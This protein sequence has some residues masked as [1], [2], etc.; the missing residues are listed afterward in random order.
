MI[1]E[2]Y[3][4][5]TF[6]F[7]EETVQQYGSAHKPRNADEELALSAAAFEYAVLVWQYLALPEEAKPWA[8]EKLREYRWVLKWGR[9]SKSR[10]IRAAA[11]VLGLKN[12]A[13]L[14]DF[15]QKHRN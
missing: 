6:L 8:M 2:K 3:Y 9:S 12:A 5:D 14:A 13:R 1:T 7:V 11:S 4:R 10:M 15:Y